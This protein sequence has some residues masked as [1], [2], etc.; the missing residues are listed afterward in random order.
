MSTHETIKTKQLEPDAI[1]RAARAARK[2][3]CVIGECTM[4]ARTMHD[5][6]CA[7]AALAFTCAVAVG[8]VSLKTPPRHHHGGLDHTD[9]NLH[10][11]RIGLN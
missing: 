1:G 5:T 3:A 6:A 7:C 4:R 9:A 8:W 2:H 10:I 11:A